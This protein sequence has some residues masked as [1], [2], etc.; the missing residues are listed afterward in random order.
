MRHSASGG[1]IAGVALWGGER[2]FAFPANER[3]LFFKEKA[4]GFHKHSLDAF[5]QALIARICHHD[6]FH[7]SARV[8]AITL[9]IEVVEA[10]TTQHTKQISGSAPLWI[11]ESKEVRR[12]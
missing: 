2:W 5:R 11:D 7:T 12:I 10:I 9:P 1:K 4:L 3:C 8:L 6:R